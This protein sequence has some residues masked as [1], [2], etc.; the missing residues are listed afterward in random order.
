[1]KE[2]QASIHDLTEESGE[3]AGEDESRAKATPDEGSD[4]ETDS[5]DEEEEGGWSF[6]LL[7]RAISDCFSF[8]W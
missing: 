3:P 7:P 2:I 6:I 4:D 8:V 5:E 1:M